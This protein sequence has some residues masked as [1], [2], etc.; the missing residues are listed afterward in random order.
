MNL[1]IATKIP[2]VIVALCVTVAVGV[3]T[4][5]YVDFRKAVIDNNKVRLELLVSERS[6][7]LTEWFDT[8][9]SVM[10]TRAEDPTTVNALNRFSTSFGLM[11]EDP[12]KDLQAA[13]IAN[14]P[15]PTGQKDL[16]DKAP[17]TIPYN[18]AHADFHPYFRALKDTE[19]LY[20]VFLFDT[21]GNLIYSVYKEADYATNFI[22]GEFSDSGLGEAYREALSLQ[23]AQFYFAD[24][25]PYAPSAFA[26]ASFLATP[27][28]SA[29]DTLIGVFAIQIPV[30]RI[31]EII[32]NPV[33]LGE[34]GELYLVGSDRAARSHSR[35]EDSFGLLSTFA[36]LPQI[37]SG[38]SGVSTFFEDVP[39]TAGYDVLALARG[40]T[41]VNKQWGII[42]EVRK[43]EVMEEVLQNRNRTIIMVSIFAGVAAFLGAW[44]ARSIT[45]PLA[46]LGHEMAAVSEKRYETE[47]QG[48]ARNDEIGGLSGILV[49]FRDALNA[50][51]LRIQAQQE[52]QQETERVVSRLSVAM[53]K[54]A[55]GDLSSNIATPF[56][57]DYD[58]LRQDYNRIIN[59]LS[60]TIGSVVRSANDI[61]YRGDAMN[62]ASD[63]LSHRTENQAATLEET[64]AALDQITGSVRQAAE[65]AREV[66]QVVSKT[67]SDADKSSIVVANAVEAM[68]E[69]EIASNKVAT[70]ID[71]IDDI[72]F[73]TNLLAL[74]AGVEAARA[75]ESG[76][77]FAVV[78]SE[79][80]SLA[81]RST[82]AADE[83][84]KLI[85]GSSRQV[86]VGVGHVGE[87]GEVLTK[88]VERIA[89]IS[90]LVS[91]IAKSAQDQSS[92]IDE[93]NIGVGQLDTVTQQNAGMVHNSAESSRA[94][95]NEATQ[96][97]NLVAHFKLAAAE[98]HSEMAQAPMRM[99][100]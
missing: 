2:A 32:N 94:L 91:D 79:V 16:Y 49:E 93:I 82:D 3:G 96:L 69:I 31:N 52:H 4:L 67:R 23:K 53:G 84:K 68:K 26:P 7:A 56:I 45:K 78:A 74:N 100:S 64:A 58:Q 62:S 80:R 70:I 19:G 37:D 85:A 20:D 24:F 12:M 43:S 10:R 54:L 99:A 71:V 13:Y 46:Q 25:A 36:D 18:F 98:A 73:Q 39:G 6:A 92:S 51:D 27:V 57:A 83:I 22:T 95:L 17:E 65:A 28:F 72:A 75:G 42:A 15:N 87:T 11:M 29:D 63:E 41:I 1:R 38:V 90:N 9:G 66:E 81:Q 34:T 14:N 76:K 33:G 61:K 30:E 8:I 50:S 5:G 44:F 35:F 89:Q 88:I 60:G 55:D 97:N 40:I 48:T 77:G 47:I 86:S 21:Q 59:N